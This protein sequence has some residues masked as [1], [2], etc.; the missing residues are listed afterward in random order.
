MPHIPRT[1]LDDFE[2]LATAPQQAALAIQMA[3]ARGNSSHPHQPDPASSLSGNPP[4]ESNSAR[5]EDAFRKML[6]ALKALLPVI[7]RFERLA[8]AG[9]GGRREGEL[10][11]QVR[12]II[13]EAEQITS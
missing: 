8:S 13:R 12:N 11:A 3:S 2:L 10:F 1:K 4:A 6:K 9:S 7:E 5:L